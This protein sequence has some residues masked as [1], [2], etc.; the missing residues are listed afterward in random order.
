[1]RFQTI[2]AIDIAT[3]RVFDSDAL[4]KILGLDKCIKVRLLRHGNG[5]ERSCRE[6]ELGH[7]FNWD[8]A[9]RVLLQFV[10]QSPVQRLQMFSAVAW[11]QERWYLESRTTIVDVG[12]EALVVSKIQFVFEVL[13]AVRLHA[14]DDCSLLADDFQD[15]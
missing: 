4:Q 12:I 8:Q 2:F 14:I 11:N 6:H 3:K 1:L 10:P 5:D 7:D 15:V 9:R 13:H